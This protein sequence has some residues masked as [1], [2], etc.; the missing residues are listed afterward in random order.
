[1]SPLHCPSIALIACL[2]AP[3]TEDTAARDSVSARSSTSVSRLQADGIGVVGGADPVGLLLGDARLAGLRCPVQP[4]FLGVL[5]LLLRHRMR[6]VGCTPGCR[7]EQCQE[8]LDSHRREVRRTPSGLA[9]VVRAAGS[10]TP[11]AVGP[12]HV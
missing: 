3:G 9:F 7:A 11:E 12:H 6:H 1:M 4:P 8:Q 10:T 2:A 5:E